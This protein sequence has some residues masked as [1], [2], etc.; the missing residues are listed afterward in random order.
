VIAPA[1]KKTRDPEKKIEVFS[2]PLQKEKI[3]QLM[4]ML[5][6]LARHQNSNI[7]EQIPKTIIQQLR[8]RQ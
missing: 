5:T 3:I 6:Y 7:G 1:G 4:S 8:R 2:I